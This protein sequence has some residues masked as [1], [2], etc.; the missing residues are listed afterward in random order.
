ME[1]IKGQGHNAYEDDGT[2]D[3]ED[4]DVGDVEE[5][6]EGMVKL[7]ATQSICTQL[8]RGEEEE[9]DIKIGRYFSQ[10]FRGGR[11]EYKCVE[12]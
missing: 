12:I 7:K 11:F 2:D 10:S 6:D 9:K 3:E 1:W 4:D 8:I 5:N